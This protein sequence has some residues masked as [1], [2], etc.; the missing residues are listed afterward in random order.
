[1]LFNLVITQIRN[2]DTKHYKQKVKK[3]MGIKPALQK[4][5][6]NLPKNLLECYMILKA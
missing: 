5:L 4:A 1:M 2:S 3:F 6:N